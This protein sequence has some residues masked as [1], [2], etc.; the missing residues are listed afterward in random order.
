MSATES[1][2]GTN[3]DLTVV[4]M[5]DTP[6]QAPDKDDLNYLVVLYLRETLTGE[7]AALLDPLDRQGA[8]RESMRVTKL[9]R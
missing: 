4:E 3:S 8:L 5:G 2:P 6:D 1:L 9:F 7:A